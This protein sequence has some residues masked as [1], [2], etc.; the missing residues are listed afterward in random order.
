[1][2]EVSSGFEALSKIFAG[3]DLGFA[4]RI[5]SEAYRPEGSVGRPHRSLLGM[6]KAE[7]AKRLGGVRSYRELC[8]LL[9]VDGTLRSLCEIKTGEKPYDRSTLM[10]FRQR[11][12]PERLERVMFRLVR[13]LDKMSVLEGRGLGVGCYLH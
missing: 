9:E 7:L 3:R 8:R 13:Q 5:L 12:G 10:R 11:V 4:E 1:M 2:R 6:F